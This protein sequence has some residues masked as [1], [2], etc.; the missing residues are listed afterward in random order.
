MSAFD[1]V[2]LYPHI[3]HDIVCVGYGGY[4]KKEDCVC[5]SVECEDCNE[6]ILSYDKGDLIDKK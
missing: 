6:V 2:S 1:F 5:V 3:G 4:G